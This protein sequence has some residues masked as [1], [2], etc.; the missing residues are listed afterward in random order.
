MP[1]LSA[2]LAKVTDIIRR[3]EDY[4]AY[5]QTKKLAPSAVAQLQAIESRYYTPPGAS[6][7]VPVVGHLDGILDFY[8]ALLERV[9]DPLTGKG[10]Y[11]YERLSHWA[12]VTIKLNDRL[13]RHV[14]TS[15]RLLRCM[16]A[17]SPVSEEWEQAVSRLIADYT[18]AVEETIRYLKSPLVRLCCTDRAAPPDKLVAATAAMGGWGEKLPAAVGSA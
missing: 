1:V 13:V 5:E 11:T 17:D 14:S 2:V 6:E 16:P 15:T 8:A 18:D 7:S 9:D 12:L 10:T 3:L 4:Y